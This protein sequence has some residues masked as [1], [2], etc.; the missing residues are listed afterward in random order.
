MQPRLC[1]VEASPTKSKS[2]ATERIQLSVNSNFTVALV[3]HCFGLWLAKKSCATLL[4]NQK[5]K[6]KPIVTCLHAFSRTWRR[7]HVLALSSD[8][9]IGLSAS[10]V[11]S[12]SHYFG[13]TTLNWKLL[14]W[15]IHTCMWSSRGTGLT[16]GWKLN[17]PVAL[18]P[19]HWE[20]SC[21]MEW[22][23]ND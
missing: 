3:L 2:C 5:L 21:T 9:F 18:T 6:P 11:I 20:T 16:L 23:I 7:L 10:S 8:W 4:T 22:Q 13:F 17:K 1:W 19:N 14:L 12:Q 15:S